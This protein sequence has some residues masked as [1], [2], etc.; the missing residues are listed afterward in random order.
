MRGTVREQVKLTKTKAT[1]QAY[2]QV[3]QC[4]KAIERYAK[5][6]SDVAI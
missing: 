2:S 3:E 6:I 5:M 1:F 4:K